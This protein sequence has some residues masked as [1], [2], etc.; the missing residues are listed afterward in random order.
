[1]L[2][3]TF[4]A[5]TGLAPDYIKDLLGYNDSRRTL[6][7]SNN[8]LLMSL[9]QILKRMVK[10]FFPWRHEG[11]GFHHQRQFLRLILRLIFLSVHLINF[12][13]FTCSSF[14]YFFFE[15]LSYYIAHLILRILIFRVL[16]YCKASWTINGRWRHN[17]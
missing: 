16:Q 6:R 7:S 12:V 3:L 4:K 9:E 1:M 11:S 15:T 14:F 10:E 13:V 2:L 8:K 5:L 17:D